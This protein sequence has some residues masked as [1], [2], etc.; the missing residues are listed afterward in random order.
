MRPI[1]NL[2]A[3]DDPVISKETKLPGVTDA[4]KK[5]ADLD[6][7]QKQKESAAALVIQKWLRG[8]WG[9]LAFSRQ[10]FL[11]RDEIELEYGYFAEHYKNQK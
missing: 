9:R 2:K 7:K 8:H 6:A 5:Q 3:K 1:M 4:K 11:R 10:L